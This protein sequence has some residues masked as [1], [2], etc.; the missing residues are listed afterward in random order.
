MVSFR[1]IAW[2][3]MNTFTAEVA[4]ALHLAER[5]E[6]QSFSALTEI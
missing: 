4:E 1:V 2:K 5:T 6:P 3:E